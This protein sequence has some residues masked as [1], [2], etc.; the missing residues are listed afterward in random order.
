MTVIMDRLPLGIIS[1]FSNVVGIVGNSL[2]LFVFLR[3]YKQPSN[4]K[5]FVVYMAIQDLGTSIAHIAKEMNRMFSGDRQTYHLEIA[6][7]LSHYVG[8]SVGQGSVIMAVFITIERYR[9]ICTP[10]KKQITTFQSKI[11]VL[12]TLVASAVIN[13]P[14]IFIIGR[15]NVVI[16]SRNA[17]RCSVKNSHDGNP[18][19]IY[20]FTFQA[21][22]IACSII[23][24][25]VLMSKILKRLLRQ[26]KFKTRDGDSKKS[27]K[28][29]TIHI[30]SER[31]N[32][33]GENSTEIQN[34]KSGKNGL[35]SN[36]ENAK[37]WKIT[38]TFSI[39]ISLLI[40]SYATFAVLQTYLCFRRYF[41]YEM[42]I[43]DEWD[44]VIE[45]LPDVVSFNGVLNPV[46]YF[47]TDTRFRTEVCS[48]FRH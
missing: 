39:V 23:V 26:S 21:I 11:M 1:Y 30:Q 5:F 31:S 32:E 24:I 48:L 3:R 20:F 16:D 38:R 28:I 13:I 35:K 18:L 7:T 4:Y 40:T 12:I 17:T 9:K 2:V 15:R 19:S 10:F 8:N 45:Y 27:E 14:M 22:Q 43:T 33:A 36:S 34:Q 47:Y 46:V 6:C 42:K 44:K 41:V 37:N 25:I 29:R